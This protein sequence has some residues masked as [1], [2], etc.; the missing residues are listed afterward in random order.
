MKKDL[1]KKWE[2]IGKEPGWKSAND[3]EVIAKIKARN[4]TMKAAKDAN[5]NMRIS[6]VD[7]NAFKQVAEAKGLGYQTLL[8]SLI[9][10]YVSGG[11]VEKSRPM[12]KAKKQKAG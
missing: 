6:S 3:P 2:K 11:L 9:R 7:L 12:L 4:A 1:Q 10:Q 5:L 8:T